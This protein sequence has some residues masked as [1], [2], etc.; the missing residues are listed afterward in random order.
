MPEPRVQ[1]KYIGP[2][3]ERTMSILASEVDALCATKFWEL[4]K[5]K[6]DKKKEEEVSTNG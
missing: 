2:G 4:D 3:G 1:V 5:K 6:K